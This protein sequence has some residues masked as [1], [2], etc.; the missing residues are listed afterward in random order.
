MTYF[1]PYLYNRVWSELK[2][3]NSLSR[4]RVACSRW[5]GVDTSSQ[6]DTDYT[7]SNNNRIRLD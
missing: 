1:S 2:S 4:S 6:A 3:R 7:D 5:S